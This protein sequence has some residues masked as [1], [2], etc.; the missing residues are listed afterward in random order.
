MAFSAAL[1]SSPSGDVA[2]KVEKLSFSQPRRS[3]GGT[4][5]LG[6][7][8]S[9]CVSPDSRVS[10][11]GSSVSPHRVPK[12][13]HEGKEKIVL[14][15]GRRRG[16]EVSPLATGS[17]RRVSESPRVGGGGD[18]EVSNEGTISSVASFDAYVACQET[19]LSF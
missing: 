19:R 11:R 3:E 18:I 6:K 14:D 10:P 9:K 17:P 2:S 16:S 7:S 8:H 15:S 13:T 12:R 5:V 1:E 4:P